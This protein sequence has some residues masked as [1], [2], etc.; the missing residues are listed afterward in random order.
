MSLT[1]ISIVANFSVTS[2]N[3]SFIFHYF[4]KVFFFNKYRNKYRV[5]NE[6]PVVSVSTLL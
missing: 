6:N 4:F 5:F 2:W 1:G 3:F